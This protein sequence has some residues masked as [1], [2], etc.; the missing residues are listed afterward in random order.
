MTPL[1]EL[2]RELLD[3]HERTHANPELAPVRRRRR[4][5]R[6]RM[7]LASVMMLALG[8]STA[9]GVIID[10]H[11]SAPLTGPLPRELL[12]A[13][14]ELSVAPDL[15]AGRAGWCIE[16]PD[17]GS[18]RSA[19]PIPGECGTTTRGGAPFDCKRGAGRDLSEHRSC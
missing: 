3:A 2:R 4:R 16:L 19:A 17:I 12:G 9:T 6:R 7:T 11:R 1:G 14:Y 10:T 15:T 8:G 18:P 13:R 5:R